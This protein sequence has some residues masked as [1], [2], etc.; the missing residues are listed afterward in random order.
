MKIF[1]LYNGII[2]GLL[3][4]IAVIGWAT[5]VIDVY[6]KTFLIENFLRIDIFHFFDRLYPNLVKNT[7][8]NTI[9]DKVASCNAM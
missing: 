7:H 3:S 4:C 2:T 8:M 6:V 1:V 5:G 9:G